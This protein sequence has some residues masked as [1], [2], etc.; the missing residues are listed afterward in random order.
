MQAPTPAP[1]ALRDPA[2]LQEIVDLD[3]FSE[4][5]QTILGDMTDRAAARF[6]L[7]ISLVS[8]VLDEA[9]FFAAK[10]GID[11]G[12]IADAGGTPVEWAFCKYTVEDRAAFVVEDAAQHERTRENPLVTQEGIR[13]YAG[14]PMTT[15]KGH[16]LGSFCV[17]G[18]EERSFSDEDLADLRALAAEVVQRIERRAGREVAAA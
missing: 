9:Q 15:S 17:I 8:V 11:E 13:C 7:P 3:L 4:D 16:V 5:V 10:H 14:I 12:W 18:P 1:D 6:D 2:R